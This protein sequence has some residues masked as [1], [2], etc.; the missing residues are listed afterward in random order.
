MGNTIIAVLIFGALVTVLVCMAIGRDAPHGDLD[1]APRYDLD[2]LFAEFGITDDTEVPRSCCG[3]RVRIGDSSGS[4]TERLCP[5]RCCVE[6]VCGF[7]GG[8]DGGYGPAGCDC[9]E[10]IQ[11]GAGNG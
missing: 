8:V 7:C 4:I 5:H 3:R 11:G 1:D 9:C 10:P 2:E 6:W